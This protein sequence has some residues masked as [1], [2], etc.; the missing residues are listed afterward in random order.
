MRDAPAADRRVRRSAPGRAQAGR[1]R[2]HRHRGRAR[3]R[4]TS[5]SRRSPVCW[6]GRRSRTRRAGTRGRCSSRACGAEGYLLEIKRKNS[7]L[8]PDVRLPDERQRLGEGRGAAAVARLRGGRQRA[9]ADFVFLNTCAVREKAT[10]KFK[11]S[12]VRLGR[13][14]ADR[15]ELQIGV[16]GCV[17]QLEGEALLERRAVR[18]TCWW[19]LTTCTASRSFSRRRRRAGGGG[20]P[21]PR[22][23]RLRDPRRGDGAREPGARLRHGDGGLQPRL[24][25]L[26]RAADARPRGEPPARRHRARGRGPRRR[27]ATP[28]SCC[29]GRPSTP[30]GTATPTSPTCSRASTASRAPASALHDLPPEHVDA[31]IARR[32]PRPARAS[33]R[34]ST[35]RSSPARTACSPR[36]AA[37]TRASST[38]TRS[39]CCA[40]ASPTSPSRPT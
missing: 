10:A 20:R 2:A 11:H 39:R 14:K 34:T 22:G 40:T 32:P 26:R 36:C 33:A 38:S 12:L 17:A 19:A 6:G 31:R 7:L 15:P 30:T 1:A 21:R 3:C 8:H 4:T 16:G 29:S 35:C 37:A 28:R 9:D 24:Q 13:L 18:S 27:A 23:G 25:L 5:A